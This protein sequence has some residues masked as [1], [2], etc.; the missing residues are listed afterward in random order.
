MNKIIDLIKKRIAINNRKRLKHE[1]FSIISNNCWG[2]IAYQYLDLEYSSPTIGL[3]IP[4]KDFIKFCNNLEFYLN[5]E[6]KQISLEQ[7]KNRSAFELRNF[8]SNVPVIGKIFDIE[9]AFIHYSSFEDALI[10]RNRRK[11]RIRENIIYKFNDDDGFDL[12]DCEKL[13][14]FSK[15][16][17]TIFITSNKSYKNLNAKINIYLKTNLKK[18]NGVDDTSNFYRK[19]KIVNIINKLI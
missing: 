17:N 3:Y 13:E 14:L 8:K 9:I 4:P 10:K 19:F 11:L 6:I 1:N 12:E 16:H 15:N 5:H 18:L 7:S 2:G